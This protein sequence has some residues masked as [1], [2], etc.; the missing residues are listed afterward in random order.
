MNFVLVSIIIPNF[1]RATLIGETLDSILDQSYP[2][3]ECIVVDDGSTDASESVV[4]E[5]IEKDDRVCFYKRP[6]NLPKG[7]NSCRNFGFEASKGDYIQWL[8]SDDL[9]DPD[10]LFLQ[11]EAL[12]RGS[13][14]SV[15][16]CKFGYFADILKLSV[17]DQVK[18]YADFKKGIAL[19]IAFGTYKEYFPPHVYL[20]K[21]TV[22]EEAG[23]WD[24]G[25]NINQDGEFFTRVLLVSQKIVFVNTVVYYRRTRN[26]NVSLVTTSQKAQQLIACWELIQEHI[27]KVTGHKTH[28][29]VE[30]A[31]KII[32]NKLKDEYP[33]VVA[34]NAEFFKPAVV[35][36]HKRIFKKN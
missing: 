8:D 14:I 12:K 2:H 28:V 24:E 20:T 29:Y 27:S 11:V 34:Q 16:I 4:R 32:L 9:L 7:A 36:F 18:T 5:F 15:A 35:P 25:L 17:R 6:E 21:R 3:W 26:D 10:K 31:K 30:T 22:I 33:E 1:N 23:L 19:L 13:N